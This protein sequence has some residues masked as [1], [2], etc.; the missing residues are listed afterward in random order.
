MATSQPTLFVRGASAGEVVKLLQADAFNALAQ[1]IADDTVR[2][3]IE[4]NGR[5]VDL[6]GER[7]IDTSTPAEGNGNGPEALQIVERAL[8]Y[9]DIRGD[10]AFPWLMRRH[11]DAPAL[12]QFIEKENGND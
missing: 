9:I 6:D 5:V 11:M 12:V 1:R 7:F 2:A 8:R 3:D 4:L 10:A